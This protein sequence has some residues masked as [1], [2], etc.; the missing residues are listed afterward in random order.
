[1]RLT[2]NQLRRIIREAIQNAG[3]LIESDGD[4]KIRDTAEK[5][6]KSD[7]WN[8][9]GSTISRG[10]VFKKTKSKLR[11]SHSYKDINRVCKRVC[12]EQG[13]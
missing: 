8:N 7:R 3:L 13:L 11:K 10:E 4:A 1:M 9:G 5:I 2:Q 6:I 12:D